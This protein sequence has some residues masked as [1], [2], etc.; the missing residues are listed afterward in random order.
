MNDNVHADTR[1]C[2]VF[3]SIIAVLSVSPVNRV[4]SSLI[5]M[6]K[7]GYVA[8]TLRKELECVSTPTESVLY[9]QFPVPF[10]NLFATSESRH[11]DR[12]CLFQFPG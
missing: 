6:P 7:S 10:F 1:S 12:S 4:T 5:L 8:I 2:A 3:F 11:Y 9:L